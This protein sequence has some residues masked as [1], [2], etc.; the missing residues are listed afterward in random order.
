MHEYFVFLLQIVQAEG[1]F[2]LQEDI[3]RAKKNTKLERRGKSAYQPR[4]QGLLRFQD[5]ESGV[6]PGNEVEC[7]R[8]HSLRMRHERNEPRAYHGLIIIMYE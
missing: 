2:F 1:N 6:D 8:R 4:S 5:L 3:T 7:V